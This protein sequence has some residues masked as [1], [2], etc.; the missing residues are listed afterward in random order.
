MLR[1]V[2]EDSAVSDCHTFLS[3]VSGPFAWSCQRRVVA[4][5]KMRGRPENLTKES[6]PTMFYR[7]CFGS[8]HAITSEIHGNLTCMIVNVINLALR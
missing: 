4:N 6:D 8:K 2:I 5:G 3:A 7:L 1:P